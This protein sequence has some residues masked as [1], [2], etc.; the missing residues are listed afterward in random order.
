LPHIWSSATLYTDEVIKERKTW[1]N[2]WVTQNQ[3]FD[4]DAALMFHHFGGNG[5][6]EN[7]LVMNRNEKKT[8]SI[9]CINYIS[10]VETEIIYE[11][12]IH[13]KTYTTKLITTV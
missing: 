6:K 9:S 11:D 2:T 12:V 7:D 1:F 8:V 4:K 13:K 10:K 5:D 3:S